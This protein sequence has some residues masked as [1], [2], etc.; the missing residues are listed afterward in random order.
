MLSEFWVIQKLVLG[1]A[2]YHNKDLKPLGFRIKEWASQYLEKTHNVYKRTL[3]EDVPCIWIQMANTVQAEQPQ[4]SIGI[5]LNEMFN[6]IKA[7]HVFSG[8]K[9]LLK[10]RYP[11]L[12]QYVELRTLDQRELRIIKSVTFNVSGEFRGIR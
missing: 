12:R 4:L 10:E 11:E 7:W 2:C 5:N 1:E 6:Q 8:N 3:L 9:R